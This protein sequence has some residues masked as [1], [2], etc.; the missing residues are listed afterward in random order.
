M[1]LSIAGAVKVERREGQFDVVASFQCDDVG[2]VQA[3]R[4]RVGRF[5]GDNRSASGREIPP[6][7]C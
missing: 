4:V 1:T 3:V 2:T 6:T 7:F 5:R